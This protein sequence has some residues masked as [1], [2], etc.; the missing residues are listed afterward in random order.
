MSFS[1]VIQLRKYTFSLLKIISKNPCPECLPSF[2][3][4]EVDPSACRVPPNWGCPWPRQVLGS[5]ECGLW[6]W[7]TCHRT[8]KPRRKGGCEE[9]GR[10][11]VKRR[12]GEGEVG[13]FILFFLIFNCAEKTSQEF[14][15]IAAVSQICKHGKHGSMSQGLWILTLNQN[16]F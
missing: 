12:G 16:S 11:S 3:G 1:S 15:F 2:K 7:A 13:C 8:L 6:Q 4:Q 5:E 10:C 14:Q 9:C